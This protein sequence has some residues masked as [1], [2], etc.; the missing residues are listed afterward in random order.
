MSSKRV[1]QGKIITYSNTGAAIA[2]NDPVVIGNL[3]GVALVAIIA[4]TG[5]GEVAIAEVYNLPKLDAAVIAQGETVNF[6]ISAG[7]DGEVDDNAGIPAVGDIQSFGI[8][9]EGKGATTS[10]DIAVL[11]TPGTGVVT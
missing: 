6:D 7:S 2:V 1:Q 3:V 11:L 4:T 10:E 9:Y 8:A 5:V